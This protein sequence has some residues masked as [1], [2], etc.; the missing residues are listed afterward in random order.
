[1]L[2]P[3][4]AHYKLGARRPASRA[5]AG[6]PVA[7]VI[8]EAQYDRVAKARLEELL[9]RGA[10]EIHEALEPFRA[11]DVAYPEGTDVIFL[12][13]PYRAYVKTL[14]ERQ[15]YPSA[16][17]STDGS[18]DRP[19][20]VTGWTLPDQMGVH[21]VTVE[22]PFEMPPTSRVMKAEIPAGPVWG[23]KK[24]SFWTIDAPGNTG[25]LAL[26]RLAAAGAAIS[27]TRTALDVSGFHYAPGSLVVQYNKKLQPA[28]SRVAATLGVRVDGVKGKPPST[29]QPVGR[30]RIGLYR[31]FVESIDEGWTRLVLEQYE[32]KFDTLTDQDI[33][34]GNLRA[35]YDAI[36]IPSTP[37]DRIASGY[38][39]GVVPDEYTGGLGAAGID[40]LKAF[41]SAG[42]TLV[43]L[44]QATTFGI[45]TFDLPIRDLAREDD[46]VFVPGSILKLDLDSE[47]PLAFGMP[48]HTAGF[49]AFSA[50][51]E[52]LA[53][54]DGGTP[55]TIARWGRDNPLLSGWLE[56]AEILAGRAAAVEAPFGT[57]RVVLLGFPVQ[58]RGQSLA[59]FRLLF[60]ALFTAR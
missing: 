23:E 36:I 3:W 9:M 2:Y 12:A 48:A 16:R 56:G 46:R 55:T 33:R 35:R 60:N 21:V 22:R 40:S 50:A 42:G 6:D 25:A 18:R 51:F 28:V 8:P 49:F 26:N 24:P 27:W 54:T 53:S 57:G 44:A 19:Y 39:A 43:C 29:T 45:S 41:V 38:P 14:L 5:A 30:A 34:S 31:P 37:P 47:R 32:F 59:T 10:V 4:V 1:L 58:H 20:D 15:Q 11:D 52:P 17:G 7:F 13:Q